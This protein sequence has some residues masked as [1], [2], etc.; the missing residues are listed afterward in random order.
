MDHGL[1]GR[2]A[3]LEVPI[4]GRDLLRR[5]SEP[6]RCYH[7]QRHLRE[8]LDAL[9]RL[10]PDVPLDVRL[11][12]WF[13]DA[14]HDP[15]AADNEQRSA[16]LAASALALVDGADAA[17]VARLV[18]LTATHDPSPGDRSGELLCDADLAILA[19]A[20]ARYAVYAA[21]VR[22]EYTHVSAADF[23]RGRAQVLR[24]LVAPEQIYR[25][26][27]GG[28]WER[29]ARANVAAELARLSADS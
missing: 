21:D 6:H 11:A 17:E 12:A 16:D 15:Q 14:V 8:V 10:S 2:W 27:V 13:H 29:R 20:P 28:S 7:D 24:R 25:T 26:T 3:A 9:D 5:W 22:T 4:D 19:A 18:L 23:A 1:A